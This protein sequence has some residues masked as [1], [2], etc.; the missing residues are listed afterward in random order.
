MIVLPKGFVGRLNPDTGETTL[1][2]GSAGPKIIPQAVPFSGDYPA[3]PPKPP[4]KY[5]GDPRNLLTGEPDKVKC[6]CGCNGAQQFH[7]AHDCLHPEKQRP[8]GVKRDGSPRPAEPGRAVPTVKRKFDKEH[9][10]ELALYTP[11]RF[12]ELYE[13]AP[14]AS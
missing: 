13:A 3:T 12:C 9:A 1:P 8:A 14:T 10:A 4:C 11:C 2:D 5:L 7:R 6:N